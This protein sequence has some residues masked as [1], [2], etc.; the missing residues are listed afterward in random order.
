MEIRALNSSYSKSIWK[1]IIVH[2][3]ESKYL[4]RTRDKNDDIAI[5]IWNIDGFIDPKAFEYESSFNA[6]AREHYR[7]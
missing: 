2:K 4:R 3:A 6:T 1:N 7:K 5:N